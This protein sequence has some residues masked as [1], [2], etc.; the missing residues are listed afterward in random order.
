MGPGEYVYIYVV[1]YYAWL[2]KS[3]ADG[4]PFQ[5]TGDD[6]DTDTWDEFEVRDERAERIRRTLNRQVLPMLRRQ[7]NGVAPDA[8]ENA[9][10][11]R[12]RQTL[13]AEVA[14][15]ESDS[16][17]LP[18]EDGVP[19]VVRV[20]LEPYRERLEASYSS[21]CNALEIGNHQ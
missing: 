2:G 15:L 11:G 20:S 17:R 4:P 9:T 18:W 21:L 14:A 13:A 6:Q 8:A 5:L 12:W 16:Y 10:M 3:P 7:L 1:S 19:D